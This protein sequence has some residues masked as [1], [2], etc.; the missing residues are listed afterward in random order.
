MSYNNRLSKSN[1][2]CRGA[3]PD[4]III[5][6][7]KLNMNRFVSQYQ[8]Y[9]NKLVAEYRNKNAGVKVAP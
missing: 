6:D 8:H 1:D 3:T 5:D 4:Q 2:I 9:S 7:M